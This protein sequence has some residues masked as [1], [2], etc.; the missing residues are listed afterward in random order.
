MGMNILKFQKKFIEFY[1]IGLLHL[2]S[3]N[4]KSLTLKST[5]SINKN[6]KKKPLQIFIIF[7]FILSQSSHILKMHSV[8]C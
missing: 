1:F 3:I 8:E 7:V 6:R 5:K 2:I 4:L